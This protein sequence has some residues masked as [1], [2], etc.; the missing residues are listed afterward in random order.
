MSF[1]ISIKTPA[2]INKEAVKFK[3]DSENDVAE[4]E[5][6]GVI[7]AKDSSQV[8]LTSEDDISRYCYWTV[9]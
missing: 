6:D 3:K 1:K 9:L 8:A 7:P 4:V 5:G 2:D